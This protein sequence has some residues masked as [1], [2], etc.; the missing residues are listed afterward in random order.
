M[1]KILTAF[2]LTIL[3]A[4]VVY[5]DVGPYDWRISYQFEV[6]NPVRWL[7]EA[8]AEYTFPAKTGEV[9]FQLD[10]R[11]AHYT[12]SYRKHIRSFTLKDS[13][14][15]LVDFITDTT[16]VYRVSGLKGTYSANYYIV[17]DHYK[18]QSALGLDDTPILWGTAAIFP[19]ASVVVYPW[20]Q[21]GSRIG[22]IEVSFKTP[23]TGMFLTPYQPDGENRYK[24]ED[25]ASLKSEYW[26][27]GE[28]ERFV[29]ENNGDSVI[30]G[31]T[32][33]GLG[34]KPEDLWP[35]IEKVLDFYTG[36][37]GSLPEHRTSASV[38][39]TPSS[40]KVA[41]IN[42]FGATGERSINFLL[43]EKID[44]EKLD[45]Q[46]GFICYNILL[47]WTPRHFGPTPNAMLDWFTVGVLNYTQL[48]AMMQLG[49]I[50]ETDFLAKLARTYTA[51]REQLERKGLS[52]SALMN[53]PKSNDRSV[54]GFMVCA[55]FDFLLHSETDGK[56]SLTDVL[57]TLNDQYGGSTGYTAD[58]LNKILADLGLT[59]VNNLMDKYVRGSNPI[60]LDALLKPYGYRVNLESSG[61][62]DVGLR[63]KGGKDLMVDWIDSHGP[64][65]KAGIEFGDIISEVRGFKL[66]T[67]SDLPK[68]ISKLTPGTKVNVTYIRDGEKHKTKIKLGDLMIYR[69]TAVST[70][71]ESTKASWEK[72][73]SI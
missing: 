72:F 61:K 13:E 8:N 31:I 55:M 64:A 62:P 59:D 29:Y 50:S 42:N 3:T 46:M 16:G 26:A 57:S 21:G 58:G 5:S 12:E 24:V 48:K 17:M 6:V 33:S 23:K 2:I 1:R 34:F 54:Y 43:D 22:S 44:L 35:K 51:Y 71:P 73:K 14:G 7:I 20:D 4:G 49:F 65:H 69:V 36:V 32:K 47:S 40:H 45:S 67:S 15:N 18:T 27:V 39:F 53:L 38:Y 68:L 63:L 56:K 11:D 70:A 25:I 41:S 52:L 10:D 28:F 66:S 30:C 60:S 19:G 37:F 9:I